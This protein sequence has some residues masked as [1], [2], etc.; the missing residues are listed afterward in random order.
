MKAA[1]VVAEGIAKLQAAGVDGAEQSVAWW[2][3]EFEVGDQTDLDVETEEKIRAGFR[4][5]A[6]HEPLQYVIGHAPFLDFSLRTDA[7]ALAPRPE[8]EELVTRV[9]GDRTFWS[10]SNCAVADIGTGTGCIAIALA[11]GQPTARI[12]AVDRSPDAL[13]LARENAHQTGT[14]ER[15]TFVEGDL[16]ASFSPASLDLVVSNP[17]YIARPVIATLDETVRRFEPAAALD[18]GVDGLEIIR[19]LVEQSFT[20]LKKHGRLWLEIGD[21]QGDAVRA[22]L[23][24]AGF[25][26]VTIHRDMYQLNRFAEAVT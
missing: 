23:T 5:L 2:V 15:I 6:D 11:R 19:R 16:L 18:G 24:S 14:S 1:D 17:P 20:V 7:R 9:L 26:R 25:Q 8:T 12:W 13:N 10:R 22:L 4:R 3:A 21:E